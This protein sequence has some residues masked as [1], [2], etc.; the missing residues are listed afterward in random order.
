MKLIFLYISRYKCLEDEKIIFDQR[1]R[2]TRTN[3]LS[4]KSDDIHK[5]LGID[6]ISAFV[7]KNGSGKSTL[8]E[9]ILKILSGSD[10]LFDF[11]FVFEYKDE[12]Y[13]I[14][15]Q[16][17]EVGAQHYEVTMP[18]KVKRNSNFIYYSPIYNPHSGISDKMSGVQNIS[19]DRIYRYRKSKNVEED[20]KIQIPFLQEMETFAQNNLS[21][22]KLLDIDL[23]RYN[24]AIIKRRAIKA[25]NDLVLLPI[26][27]R[28]YLLQMSKQYQMKGNSTFN[29][30]LRALKDRTAFED[31]DYFLG[32]LTETFDDFLYF[33]DNRRIVDKYEELEFQLL[34]KM[35]IDNSQFNY[36][37]QRADLIFR[38]LHLLF[39]FVDVLRDNVNIRGLK[40]VD[41]IKP[42][43]EN[44]KIVFQYEDSLKH[45]SLIVSKTRGRKLPMSYESDQYGDALSFISTIR[46][47]GFDSFF[48]YSWRGI[49]SGQLAK[50]NFYSRL[51]HSMVSKVNVSSITFI[52]DEADIYLHP[53]WQRT[54]FDDFNTFLLGYSSFFKSISYNVILTTHSPM[55]ISDLYNFSV[56]RMGESKNNKTGK[57]KKSKSH[58]FAANL[59]DLFEDEFDVTIPRGALATKVLNKLL[60]DVQSKKL[61]EDARWKIDQVGESIIKRSLKRKLNAKH[62][63]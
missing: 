21:F 28:D 35:I 42:I 26:E 11:Q 5:Y 38:R 23:I 10:D 22:D 6:T 20:L 39:S 19:S 44:E 43:P 32:K 50:L 14:G 54:F 40:F 16:F 1:Y 17:V 13:N 3:R 37:K 12:I 7:G 57:I 8:L 60:V 47:A 27:K 62:P 48:K 56:F 34:F 63:N 29:L 52:F 55:M 36:S 51:H 46:K 15:D 18:Q 41:R 2:L 30:F 49:S 25:L 61:P 31:Y 24:P 45:L 9:M 58:T 59:F 53:E 33:Y 4:K